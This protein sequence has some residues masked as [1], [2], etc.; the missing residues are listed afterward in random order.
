[1]QINGLRTEQENH[2]QYL[3]VTIESNGKQDFDLNHTTS[4]TTKLFHAVNRKFIS[5]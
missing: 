1:M 4:K 2:L 3:G 5:I